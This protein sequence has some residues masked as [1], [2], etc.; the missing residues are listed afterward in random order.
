[1]RQ[2]CGGIS[3]ELHG[4]P[5]GNRTPDLMLRR[6]LGRARVFR[7]L[8]IMA[9]PMTSRTRTLLVLCRMICAL[10]ACAHSTHDPRY[11]TVLSPRGEGRPF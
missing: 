11:S 5:G 4:D 3:L 10:G 7:E 1:M 2:C 6:T 9:R 8:V